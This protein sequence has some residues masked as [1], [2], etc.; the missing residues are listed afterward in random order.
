MIKKISLF[1]SLLFFLFTNINAQDIIVSGNFYGKNLYILNPNY[2]GNTFCIDQV[3]VNGKV[4]TDE[5]NSNSFEIDFISN[6]IE[7]NAAVEVTIKHKQNC[8]PKIIN[9]EVLKQ[10]GSFIFVSAKFDKTGKLIW[11]I[12]GNPGEGLFI[13]EQFKWQKWVDVGDANASEAPAN[14]IFGFIPKPHSGQN[15]FRIRKTDSK[16]LQVN[17][18]E[19][20][21]FSKVT[22]VMLTNPK[23]TNELSF[24]AETSYE[25][26]DDKGNFIQDGNS[27]KVDVTNLTKGKY[28]V[29]YDNKSENFTKK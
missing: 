25:I 28:W 5:I 24:S 21:L 15:V 13:I 6:G 3:F 17:S 29:N 7:L 4:I 11:T 19:V 26:Y 27:Q 10:Q 22:E 9:S 1:I 8:T 14:G 12:K 2:D 18:K 16:G 20:K 23:V